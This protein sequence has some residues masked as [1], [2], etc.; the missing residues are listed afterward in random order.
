MIDNFALQPAEFGV[1]E[2]V[3]QDTE[4]FSDACLHALSA[5]TARLDANAKRTR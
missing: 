1:S 4:R 3:A 5:H 2:H